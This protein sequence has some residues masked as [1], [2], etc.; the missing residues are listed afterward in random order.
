MQSI[1]TAQ[2]G[3]LLVGVGAVSHNILFVMTSMTV[4]IILMNKTVVSTKALFALD[5]FG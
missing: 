1:T 4:L 2:H 3:C 5:F